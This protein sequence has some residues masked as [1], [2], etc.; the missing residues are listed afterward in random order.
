MEDL[1]LQIL[2]T[3]DIEKTAD[4][5][6]RQLSTLSKKLDSLKLNF[7]IDKEILDVFRNFAKQMENVK[8]MIEELNQVVRTETEVIK[9]QDGTIKTITREYLRSGEI[10]ERI[11]T[12]TQEQ[13]KVIEESTK[14]LERQNQALE[15]NIKLTDS[16]AKVKKRYVDSQEKDTTY[17]YQ[18]GVITQSVTQT[19]NNKVLET[20]IVNLQKLQK[21]LQKVGEISTYVHNKESETYKELLV[22]YEDLNKKVKEYT[23]QQSV[24][25]E[26]Q[27]NELHKNILQL[28]TDFEGLI[29]QEKEAARLMGYGT[30]IE[31]IKFMGLDDTAIKKYAQA[32]Y[33]T[34][35][36][37]RN[38]SKVVEDG[39]SRIRTFDAIV[40][41]IDGT[42]RKVKITVD[43]A[44]QSLY[45]GVEQVGTL[46]GKDVGLIGAL[47]VAFEKFPVWLVAS[48]T[49]MGAV[50][51]IRDAISTIQELNKAQVNVQMITGATA[52]QTQE[53]T[54]DLSDLSVQLHD[55]TLNV[56][57]ASEEFLRAGRNIE[58]TKKLIEASTLMSK[59]SGQTQEET[60][61]QLIAIQNA[62]RFT[63]DQMM[64]VVDKLTT[65]DNATSTSTKELGIALEHTAATAQNAGVSFD[66]LVSYIATLS[67]VTRR[68]ASTI[69]DAMR[70]IFARIESIREGKKFD[71]EGQPLN[72]VEKALNRVGIALRETD[73]TFRN[74]S[75]VFDELAAKWN[76]LNDIERNEIATAI[77]GV[78]QREMFLTLMQHYNEALEL[79][80]VMTDSVGSAWRRYDSY[81]QSIEAHL[82]DLA[83]A[84]QR[85]WMHVLNSETI[86]NVVSLLTGLVNLL[87]AMVTRFDAL[88]TLVGAA[89]SAFFIFNKELRTAVS[90]SVYEFF[91]GLQNSFREVTVAANEAAVAIHAA[92][93][94]AKGLTFGGLLAT[95]G[96]FAITGVVG[97]AIGEVIQYIIN[98]VSEARKKAEEF[99]KQNEEMV[100]AYRNHAA[101]IEFLANKYEQLTQKTMRSIDEEK[102]LV[103]VQNELGKLM[104]YLV[105][106][107]DAQGNARLRN[108]EAIK[109]ELEYT[110]QLQELQNKE[111]VANLHKNLS[112]ILNEIDKV[113]NRINELE[114]R[115]NIN[116]PSGLKWKIGIPPQTLE[117]SIAEERE[118]IEQRRTLLELQQ[119]LTEV[120]RSS[121][122][123]YI[124]FNDIKKV[125]TDTDKKYIDTLIEQNTNTIKD[126]K[127]GQEF[128]NSLTKQIDAI[129]AVREYLSTLSDKALNNSVIISKATE[130]FKSYGLS[131]QDAEKYVA[132][133]TNRMSQLTDK[134]YEQLQ[135]V[136]LLTTIISKLKEGYSLTY[137]DITKLIAKYPDLIDKYTIENGVIKVNIQALED[138]KEATMAAYNATIQALEQE[139]EA[140]KRALIAKMPLYEKEIM[141][142]KD[143]ATARQA[144][145]DII[146]QAALKSGSMYVGSK[147]GDVYDAY[148]KLFVPIGQALEDLNN[149]K[150]SLNSI[151]SGIKDATSASNR[152]YI[153][154]ADKTSKAAKSTSESVQPYVIDEFSH[155]LAELDLQ[156][157]QSEARMASYDK[158]SEEY[159]NELNV[160]NVLLEKKRAL[161][162]SEI[163]NLNLQ[164]EALLK[165]INTLKQHNKLTTEQQKQ[166]N[167][168][169][170]KYDDNRKT[171][172]QL[173]GQIIDINKTIESNSIAILESWFDK[174]KEVADKAVEAYKAALQKEKELLLKQKDEELEI[175]KKRHEAVLKSLDEELNRYQDIIEAKLKLIDM[176]DN[177]REY[178]K[179]LTQLEE[180]RAEVQKQI[181]ILSL[182]DSREAQAKIAELKKKEAEILQKIDDLRYKHESDLRKQNLQ[183]ELEAFK[184]QIEA[185]KDAE[186]QMYQANVDRINR[187]KELI[188]AHYNTLLSDTEK[189]ES[190]RQQIIEGHTQQ[191]YEI[192]KKYLED[193]NRLMHDSIQQNGEDLLGLLGL[194]QQIQAAQTGLGSLGVP[195]T[196]TFTSKGT[197]YN[198]GKGSQQQTPLAVISPSQYKIDS[199]GSAIMPSRALASILGLTVDW[200]AQSG[201][202]IIGGKKFIPSLIDSNGVSYVPIR[203]VAAAFGHRVEYDELTGKI[204]IFDTGGY[205]GEFDGGRLAILHEKELVLN[206]E[207]TA[208]MLKIVDI[209]RNI[210]KSIETL[211]LPQPALATV[212]NN[213]YINFNIQKLEGNEDGAQILLNAFVSGLKKRGIKLA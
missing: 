56:M 62:Y 39:G 69:G 140:Q 58:E 196:G 81:I 42:F 98:S 185:K 35:V 94:A 45:K 53:W 154:A 208:N 156:L 202:V 60:A 167:D 161:I 205:T 171:I 23:T 182:D 172:E 6:N 128:Y 210:I 88:P 212:G 110:K 157:Q 28:R 18:E 46:S 130:I 17:V 57:Q 104:P 178:N 179:Q 151:G 10:I 78:Y 74:I 66:K 150:K 139:V 34:N 163:N 190:M 106:S 50:H 19:P 209:T 127:T 72:N 43:E 174:A 87:D 64:E 116:I 65:V 75:D 211:K 193:F 44:T 101:E 95:L 68:S 51:Q 144:V 16:L 122:E 13:T 187:E 7:G 37:I 73:N 31:G 132:I 103:L 41:E 166:L 67:S 20:T 162:Q 30:K 164:N 55:T 125:L 21:E 121:T 8:I 158:T 86:N 115:T 213:F 207:D 54:K 105:E 134:A 109:K 206:K 33:G 93:T 92:G 173:T 114:G 159:R 111:K 38:L 108:V 170:K 113:Q 36:E 117:G 118:L 203:V 194:I 145:D 149:L 22:T 200:D 63:A 188:E 85:L 102:Q 195:P 61:Q 96:G 29:A 77:A 147:L 4:N 138:K 199:T 124:Q 197:T 15:T 141:A 165:Q 175:E 189:F 80:G 160:Q 183:N 198:F 59:I 133:L 152:G 47:K 32:I 89:S 91:V 148:Y 136:N 5:I 119:K 135:E 184:K 1:I 177:E 99:K 11:T 40:K 126:I 107:I 90:T 2:G 146:L 100:E 137:E 129:V 12:Q 24:L 70:S 112:E 176:Q 3:L 84:G 97:F 52:Q 153:P 123:A 76:K 79:Q 9:Q 27:I 49:V 191:I 14:A 192:L 48:T 120:I 181:N 26:Q 143:V 25:S 82:N 83:N 131:A 186:N 142:I 204:S 155:K 180:E 169:L 71:P 201:M 168:L